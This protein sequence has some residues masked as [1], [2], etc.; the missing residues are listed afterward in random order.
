MPPGEVTPA[1]GWAERLDEFAAEFFAAHRVPGGSLAVVTEGGSPFVRA[2]G[3]RDREA[4]VPVAA[5]TVFGLASLT[6]SFTA[7][8]L[9]A[10]EA[11]GV[12]T[13]DDPVGAA[14]PVWAAAACGSCT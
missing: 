7:L 13:L 10:L 3:W 5:D 11:R 4:R 12:L 9:L 6:K 14:P 2:Y 1:A 8:T